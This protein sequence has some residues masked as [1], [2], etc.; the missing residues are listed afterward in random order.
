MNTATATPDKPN[1]AK[2]TCKLVGT[3]GNVFAVIGTVTRCLK[4]DGQPERAEEFK[5]AAFASISYDEVLGL[6]F[7]YVD[8]E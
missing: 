6:C 3:D 4:A 1:R 2:P 5:K 8:A 7:D